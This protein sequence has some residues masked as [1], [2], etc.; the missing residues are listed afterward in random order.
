MSHSW[1]KYYVP[2]CKSD[3]SIE[4]ILVFIYLAALAEISEMVAQLHGSMI[5]MENF[6]KLHELKKDLIG[7]DNLAIPG[8][9]SDRVSLKS[10]SSGSEIVS[11]IALEHEV[12]F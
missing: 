12:W 1:N 2:A 5:K 3:T 4:K 10:K 6:Q 8:R 9:V 11:Q 7:I